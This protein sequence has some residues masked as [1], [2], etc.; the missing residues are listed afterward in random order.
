MRSL[1]KN[2][3]MQTE[4]LALYSPS[5]SEASSRFSP[6]T[7]HFTALIASN[8]DMLSAEEIGQFA[9]TLIEEGAV[10]ICVWGTGCKRFHDIIDEV[11]VK[12]EASG[13]PCPALRG[14]TLMTTWHADDSL[15]EALWFLLSCAWPAD[16]ELESCS[17]IIMT[18]GNESW[19]KEVNDCLQDI[20]KF[21][22]E[23]VERD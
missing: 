4:V 7:K 6:P 5:L 1:G 15:K 2:Q 12:M 23:M 8:S 16:D 14:R 18:F 19:A 10:Y 17:T 22:K 20:E 11:E 21:R 3:L 9:E 13:R